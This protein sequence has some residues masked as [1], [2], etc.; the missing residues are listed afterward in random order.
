[1]CVCV[2]V[3]VCVCDGSLM[4]VF[5]LPLGTLSLFFQ[6]GGVCGCLW[7][8]GMWLV[9]IHVSLMSRGVR[10]SLKPAHNAREE[11]SCTLLNQMRAKSPKQLFTFCSDFFFL[12][13]YTFVPR[14]TCKFGTLTSHSIYAHKFSILTYFGLLKCLLLSYMPGYNYTSAPPSRPRIITV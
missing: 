10:D 3:C 4:T 1:M 7:G 8:K 5:L 2:C 6:D 9:Q 12:R 11:F 13:L 14:D